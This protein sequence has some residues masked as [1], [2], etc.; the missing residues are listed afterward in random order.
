MAEILSLIGTSI[1]YLTN[2]LHQIASFPDLIRY[3]FKKSNRETDSNTPIVILLPHTPPAISTSQLEKL[4]FS[5]KTLLLTYFFNHLNLLILDE[6]FDKA[7][8][9]A[10]I[11]EASRLLKNRISR[12]GNW[13]GTT[14]FNCGID[15][16]LYD[17]Q[18]KIAGVIPTMSYVLNVNASRS[19]Q[20]TEQLIHFKDLIIKEIDFFE[21]LENSSPERLSELCFAVGHW[22]FPAHE[23]S[24]DDLVY[25]VYLM[26]TYAIQHLQHEDP[27][28]K[29]FH[30][31]TANEL[32]GFVFI[33]RDTY[34]NGNPF[35]N[36]R[37]AV[38]VLQA[39][40]HFVIRLGSL[41][42]F[43]Q[44]LTDPEVEFEAQ[45]D[46]TTE[47]VASKDKLDN[48]IAHLNPT[49]TLALLIA[50]L[51]HDVGHPGTTND[52]MI[53]YNAPMALLFNDRSVLESY[54]S[55][56]FINKVLA[57]CWPSLLAKKIDTK[58][59]LTVRNLIISSILATDM[60]EHNEY[61]NRLKSF[62]TNNEILNHDNT[63]KL[64]SALLIK[65]ADISNVT[66]PLRV[67]SQWAMVLS[68]EFA[69]VE[70]L[71]NLINH[72]HDAA[73]IIDLTQDLTYNHVPD[74]LQE[75]LTLQP[76]LQNGQIFFINLFAE[77]LFNNI[78]EL[79]PQ[80]QYTCDIILH[81]KNFWLERAKH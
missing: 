58:T 49:Q 32:L 6:N 51:G 35:H 24:N 26:I 37:H 63:V 71:K 20:T 54:H 18:S 45:S 43:K 3:L 2:T 72:E 57:V 42:P 33:V 36:F 19:V 5:D 77:N 44:F 25:C 76:K 48:N 67:S 11:A 60:G 53:K 80:L 41:P 40:F 7:K 70:T 62:R 55:S 46:G 78:A 8:T 10:T 81:N 13:T 64:I 39:C 47:L 27:E 73:S 30:L 38:D 9:D 68:R 4:S 75:I 28:D 23:L 34:R 22:S 66:R 79:L 61:V 17:N 56:V 16:C 29:S 69:E 12:V 15:D 74:N 52:F 14:H 50:A 21:L 1:R 59:E 65:C 31:L